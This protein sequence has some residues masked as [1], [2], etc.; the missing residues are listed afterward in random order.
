MIQVVPVNWDGITTGDPDPKK[1][2]DRRRRRTVGR[3]KCGCGDGGDPVRSPQSRDFTSG[4]NVNV[5]H[6]KAA[7]CIWR[8]ASFGHVSIFK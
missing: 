4:R 3:I 1:R 2:G 5:A 7:R 8:A 6:T